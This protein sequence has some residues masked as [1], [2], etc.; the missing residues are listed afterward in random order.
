LVTLALQLSKNRDAVLAIAESQSSG[1]DI[2][3]KVTKLKGVLETCQFTFNTE[4]KKGQLSLKTVHKSLIKA[5]S[6]ILNSGNTTKITRDAVVRKT[7]Y[8]VGAGS[9]N[10]AYKEL[11]DWGIIEQGGQEFTTAYQH[12]KNN[13]PN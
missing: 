7:N 9:V 6:E 5:F 2:I 1:T 10:K 3:E 12:Y 8:S 13:P 4:I 11:K